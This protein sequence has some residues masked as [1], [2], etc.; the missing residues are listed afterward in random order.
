MILAEILFGG[1]AWLPVAVGG[2]AVLLGLIAWTYSRVTAS[3]LIRLAAALLKGLA[4]VALAVCLIEPLFSGTRPRPGSNLFL[5]VADNSRSLQLSDPGESQSRGTAMRSRMADTAPWLVQ[6]GQDFELRRYTFDTTLHP[7]QNLPTALTFAGSASGLRSSLE[8]LAE[9]FRDQPVAGILLLTDGNATDLGSTAIRWSDFPPIYPVVAGS[10]EDVLDLSVLRVAVTQTNF[11]AAP[12]TLT[13]ELGGQQLGGRP[14]ILRVLDEGGKQVEQRVLS[15]IPDHQSVTE[16]FL[17]RPEQAGVSIYRIQAC[18]EG[19]EKVLDSPGSTH[20]ATLKNNQRLVTVDRGGGPYRVL[21]VSGRP[22]WEFKFLRRAVSEDDEV[23]LVGLV[24]IARKEAKFTFRGHAGERTNPLFRGFGNDKDEQAEQYDQP[25]LLRFGTSDPDELRGGFPKS[26][27][28]L[29]QYHAIILD[30]VEASFFNQDQLSL[31]QQFVTHRGGG[32][33]MLGGKDSFAEGGYARTPI[34][35]MLPIYLDHSI[36]QP[37]EGGWRLTLTRE[38]WL[39]PWVRV[40]LT[41]AEERQRLASMPV[42]QTANFVRSIKPGASVLAQVESQDGSVW[43]ALATQPFGR[44]RCG[45]LLVG[46]LWRWDLRREDSTIS[47]LGKAWR[48]TVRWLVADVPQ[49]VKVECHRIEGKASPE[50][51]LA[52]RAFDQSYQPLDNARVVL[53]VRTPDRR[54]V[55]LNAE[56]SDR[57]AGEYAATFVPRD[58][59][60]YRAEVI[61]TAPDGGEVG[62]RQTAWVVEPDVEEFRQ[63]KPNT[64]LLNRIAEQSGGQM[65]SLDRLESLVTDLPNRKIP[66]TETRIFPLWHQGSVFLFALACLIGEWGLRRWKGL[67]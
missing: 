18:L 19:E 47:D 59:G 40:R 17:V 66:I 61:V 16:R 46:D 27:E 42:F 8:S 21:Y 25:V 32:V 48:Q 56:S 22:N 45:A 10:G 65:V 26:A 4:V 11:D 12:V 7:V 58:E 49:P 24:R 62:R 1:R 33:L 57:T 41:E 39:Q 63:L 37:P 13:V 35:E 52:V 64:E 14:V 23:Q 9:R 30:D 31:M 54:E 6:L 28:D 20:E 2:G 5:L 55:E 51:Q 3:P 38:G 50:I 43:P 60:V 36:T 53:K 15:N 67:P 44:G 34:G 29:F